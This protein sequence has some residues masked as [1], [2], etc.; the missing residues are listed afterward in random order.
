MRRFRTPSVGTVLGSAALFLALTG[1]SF[2]DVAQLARNSVGTP[3]LRN[4]AVTTPKLRNASVT[5]A[6]LRNAAVTTPKIRNNAVTLAKLAPSARI[7]GPQGPAG[8]QGPPGP[9]GAPVD[10]ADGAVTTAKL[11][12]N[13][14][15]TAKLANDAVRASK[16][17]VT[18]RANGLF[19]AAGT[20]VS[21]QQ[22]CLAGEK[23]VGGG[24]T[25]SGSFTNAQ[26][27]VTQTINSRPTVP[28]QGWEARGFNG[29]GAQRAFTVYAL[30]VN[31]G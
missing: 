14:V 17:A 18:R 22:L 24:A 3:Q 10:L 13:A 28:Q 19:V 6:K 29:G 9:P 25:W 11:A 23:V 1:T 12:N 30:C 16:L 2:A 7:P 4:N 31:A 20:T 21:I 15:T 26:A 27:Q 5:T 8:P